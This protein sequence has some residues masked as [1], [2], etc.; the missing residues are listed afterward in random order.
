MNTDA[1]SGVISGR[2]RE[3]AETATRIL[4][5]VPICDGHDSAICTINLECARQGLEVIYLGYHRS[6]RDIVRAAV[7]EDVQGIG[8]SSYNGGHVE[9][10]RETL[11]ELRRSAAADIKLFGGGGGTI[12]PADTRRMQRD[13][14]ER[15]FSPGT[16]LSE[17]VNWIKEACDRS[18]KRFKPGKVAD[19][20][21][22]DRKLGKLLSEIERSPHQLP[23]R[24]VLGNCGP[25]PVIGITGPGGVGKST[26]I[27]ELVLRFLAHRSRGRLAI[28]SNDPSAPGR[29]ALLGDRATMIYAQSDR[30]FMRSLGTRGYG[31]LGPATDACIEVLRHAGFDCVLVESAGIGQQDLPFTP[32]LVDQQ[33]LVLSADYGSRLQ[34]QKIMM[35]ETAQVVVVNKSDRAG[36]RTAVTE[37]EQRLGANQRD[38]KLIATV[39]KMHRNP[40]VDELF[41]LVM[42]QIPEQAHN[43]GDKEDIL[44]DRTTRSVH[45][46]NGFTRD[47]D[48]EAIGKSPRADRISIRRR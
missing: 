48:K 43:N 14:V 44:A 23:S 45:R 42:K 15:I 21:R 10:F 46:R 32:G 36:T 37:L 9:F 11:R 35:L 13:G 40:G 7:Q 31:G 1:R 24:R 28:L 17:M 2:Q 27:D 3:I 34:L 12:T 26:L 39:A 25:S 6:V 4:T 5:A 33:I 16:R 8:L 19:I 22:D 41:E 47:S 20:A 18:E 38:Q 30:V 29:G